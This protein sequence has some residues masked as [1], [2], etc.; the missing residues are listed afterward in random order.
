M[1]PLFNFYRKRAKPM[2]YLTQQSRLQRIH[3]QDYNSC[4]SHLYRSDSKSRTHTSVRPLNSF[5][6]C[7]IDFVTEDLT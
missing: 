5:L 7:Q 4:R 6:L 1:P 3:K 2:V